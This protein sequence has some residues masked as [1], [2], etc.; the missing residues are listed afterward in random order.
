MFVL[1]KCI[2]SLPTPTNPQFLRKCIL[3]MSKPVIESSVGIPPF[4]KPSRECDQLAAPCCP[5]HHRAAGKWDNVYI[6]RIIL[7]ISVVF[8]KCKLKSSKDK[9]YFLL[10][11]LFVCFI[12][13]PSGPAK[14]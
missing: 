8:L 2:E 6:L 3:N 7:D 10:N 9:I 14:G 11:A 4:E 13:R 1:V 12:Y 5:Q